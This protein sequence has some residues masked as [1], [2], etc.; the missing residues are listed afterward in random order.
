MGK[1]AMLTMDCSLYSNYIGDIVDLFQKI[2]W[3]LFNR[4]GEVN[5]LPLGVQ[6]SS[7]W[8]IHNL[9]NSEIKTIIKNKELRQETIGITL[10][11][12][13]SDA[14]I[15][16]LARKSSEISLFLDIN[17]KILGSGSNTDVN[18]YI[19][20]IIQKLEDAECIISCYE[21]R[22]ILG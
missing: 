3:K 8:E 5:Y 20:N 2:G 13:Q 11:H 7:D 18:W 12:E 10:Y 17:R 22:E 16:F 14:G 15:D 21:F 6:D 4:D 1:E 9:S 19:K